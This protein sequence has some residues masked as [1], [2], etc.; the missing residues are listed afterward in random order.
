MTKQVS[1]ETGQNFPLQFDVSGLKE[2]VQPPID[3]E[4]FSAQALGGFGIF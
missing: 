2:R 4:D 1:P 3:T